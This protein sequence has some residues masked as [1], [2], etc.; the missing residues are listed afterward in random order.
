MTKQHRDKDGIGRGAMLNTRKAL[1]LRRESE[2]S[3]RQ[4]KNKIITEKESQR[5]RGNQRERNTLT[6][7]IRKI[8]LH[9]DGRGRK[10]ERSS[11][12]ENLILKEKKQTDIIEDKK[13]E[14][15]LNKRKK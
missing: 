3:N 7:N 5:I 15:S 2:W 4:W 12:I 6:E 9:R 1:Q 8:E 13:R 11:E 14:N 10:S